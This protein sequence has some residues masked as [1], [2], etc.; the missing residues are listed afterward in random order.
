MKV[1]P[2][3]FHICR[4]ASQPQTLPQSLES[5]PQACS[6]QKQATSLH[7]ELCVGLHATQKLNQQIMYGTA[8]RVGKF[9]RCNDSNLEFGILWKKYALSPI[10]RQVLQ[11]LFSP[12]LNHS[13]IILLTLARWGVLFKYSWTQTPCPH[14]YFRTKQTI[15]VGTDNNSWSLHINNTL[16]LCFLQS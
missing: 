7:S 13:L 6:C 12:D 14:H 5:S 2:V 4:A 9:H 3:R 1:L 10:G 11:T 16:I 8:H 15:R